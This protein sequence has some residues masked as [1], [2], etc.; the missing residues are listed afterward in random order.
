MTST[1]S[2]IVLSTSLPTLFEP[3]WDFRHVSLFRQAYTLVR[4]SYSKPM[5]SASTTTRKRTGYYRAHIEEFDIS[6]QW[7][8]KA[9]PSREQKRPFVAISGLDGGF[10][11]A[12]ESLPPTQDSNIQS[13]HNLLDTRRF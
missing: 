10:S 7:L 8:K 5:T 9:L 13:P 4:G 2:E 3:V 12:R 6:S 11:C 1:C